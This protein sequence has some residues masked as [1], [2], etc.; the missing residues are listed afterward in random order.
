MSDLLLEISQRPQLKGMAKS[1][2]VPVPPVLTRAQGRGYVSS[3]LAGKRVVLGGQGVL[4]DVFEHLGA[5]VLEWAE[6]MEI[7]QTFGV[8]VDARGYTSTAQLD[9]LYAC[10]HAWVGSLAKHGRIVVIGGEPH[11]AGSAGEAAA[12]GGL[13][14][15]VRSIAK[16]VGGR[17]VTAHLVRV[18]RGC[19]AGIEGVLRYVMSPHAAYVN[20]QVLEVNQAL[21]APASWERVLEGKVALV[22]GAAQ[23]I[24]AATARRLAAEGATVICLDLSGASERLVKVAAE[25]GGDS[26]MVDLSSKQAGLRIASFIKSRHGKVDVVVHNA[27]VTRDRTLRRMKPEKWAQ[28][29][30]VNLRGVERVD[31]VLDEHD[32]LGDHATQV[33]LS[34]I[35]GIAGN[36]GQSNYATAK[37][38]V[39]T[40]VAWRA[41]AVSARGVR[42][43]AVAPGFIETRMTDA[44]PVAI[45][46]VGRRMNTFSQGGQP[47]DVAEAITFFASPLSHG[48]SGGVLRVCGGMMLGA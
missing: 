43:N 19:E 34:S 46:E 25:I 18:K 15:F 4:G 6:E 8:C 44:I 47:E 3:P 33:Y 28:V 38:G 40:Y 32:L 17:G 7:T 1:L 41:R 10:M 5:E 23:G 39:M 26:L 31:A 16:E 12:Q 20:G 30:D 48:L 36:M 13:E 45:R 9:E 21:S 24:G 2:G 22:T 11:A 27:G 35:A 14:G 42:V 37:A 29:L